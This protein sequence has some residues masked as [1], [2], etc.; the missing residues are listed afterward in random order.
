[1][2]PLKKAH[3]PQ[4]K[5]PQATDKTQHSQINKQTNTYVYII[6]KENTGK[7]FEK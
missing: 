7:V 6:L 3:V 4:L 5:V 2:P 1:M